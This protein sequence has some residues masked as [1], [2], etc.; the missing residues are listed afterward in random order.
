[1]R[2][3]PEQER[4]FDPVPLLDLCI[5]GLCF[6]LTGSR[7]VD[8]TGVLMDFQEFDAA[9]QILQGQPTM[10][11]L[12]VREN[13]FILFSGNILS[14]EALKYQLEEYVAEED[15]RGAALLVKVGKNVDMQLVMNLVSMAREAG[16]GRVLLAAEER[17]EQEEFL[18]TRPEDLPEVK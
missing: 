15:A 12:T 3:L 5:I 2:E 14:E 17:V 8:S 10:G 16:F 4:W 6:V 9:P 7:F 18:S 13:G 11:V 1:M